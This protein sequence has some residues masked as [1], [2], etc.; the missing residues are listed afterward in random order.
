M[1]FHRGLHDDA[2]TSKSPFAAVKGTGKLIA[3][4]S[5][6]DKLKF[7][8]ALKKKKRER[9]TYWQKKILNGGT[10]GGCSNAVA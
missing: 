5:V 9:E 7:I 1:G 2:R 10:I 6:N 3:Q 4:L 8:I